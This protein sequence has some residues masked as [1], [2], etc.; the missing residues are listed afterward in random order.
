MDN[1]ITY[2]ESC[3]DTFEQKPFCDVDSL[4][5]SCL[6]YLDIPAQLAAGRTWRGLRLAELYRAEHFDRLFSVTFA[7]QKTRELLTA[8]GSREPLFELSDSTWNYICEYP[9]LLDTSREIPHYMESD[10]RFLWEQTLNYSRY[11]EKPAEYQEDW[12]LF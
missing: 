12:L 6:A 11:I 4:I 7:P 5:L 1:I 9:E 2:A 3:L 10:S 8:L